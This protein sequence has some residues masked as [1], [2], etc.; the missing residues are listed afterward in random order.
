M[1]DLVP[2]EVSGKELGFFV[3]GDLLDRSVERDRG[4]VHPALENDSS[5]VLCK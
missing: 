2:A 5:E 3:A 4:E 1:Y